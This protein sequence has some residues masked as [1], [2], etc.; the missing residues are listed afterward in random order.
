MIAYHL[1]NNSQR[2]IQE[3]SYQML[4]YNQQLVNLMTVTHSQLNVQGI[5]MVQLIIDHVT[6]CELVDI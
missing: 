2:S 5:L 1:T 4:V 3:Y 6:V